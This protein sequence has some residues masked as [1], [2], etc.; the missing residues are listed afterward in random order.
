ME[1]I[2]KGTAMEQSSGNIIRVSHCGQKFRLAGEKA[3]LWQKGRYGFAAA[4]G[5]AVVSG[6]LGYG[7]PPPAGAGREDNFQTFDFDPGVGKHLRKDGLDGPVFGIDR[8][9]LRGVDL[10][11]DVCERIGAVGLDASQKLF[12][13]NVFRLDGDGRRLG[14]RRSGGQRAQDDRQRQEPADPLQNVGF[15][16]HVFEFCGSFLGAFSCV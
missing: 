11:I 14:P 7:F 15:I 8:D 9:V 2:S 13:R 10:G 1:Y 5:A 4:D 16:L 6:A 3:S 12:D